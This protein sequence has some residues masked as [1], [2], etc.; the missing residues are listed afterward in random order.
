MSTTVS[1]AG[2]LPD[3]FGI[4]G[5]FFV[6]VPTAAASFVTAAVGLANVGALAGVVVDGVVDVSATDE[7]PVS[8]DPLGI[9]AVFVPPPHAARP[10]HA[11]ASA[12]HLSC[13]LSRITAGT[14]AG[15]P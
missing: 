12:G 4:F 14:L 10:T 5:F 3:G 2:G 15:P 9:A 11:A 1:F 7:L 8:P 13:L 6:F